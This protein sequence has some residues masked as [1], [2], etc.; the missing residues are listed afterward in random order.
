MAPPHWTSDE[1]VAAERKL[2]ELE[3]NP[4]AFKCCLMY[5]GDDPDKYQINDLLYGYARLI[6][7]RDGMHGEQLPRYADW[8]YEGQ[9]AGGSHM[10]TGY[11]RYIDLTVGVGWWSGQN[12]FKGQGITHAG[13]HFLYEGFWD[14]SLYYQEPTLSYA[15]TDLRHQ[16]D[17]AKL[18]EYREILEERKNTGAA[19]PGA[20][21]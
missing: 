9:L 5:N 10:W 2:K 17:E 16:F 11:G 3:M 21:D 15:V 18:A 8:I 14:M 4:D 19:P 1:Q 7:Y 6:N 20:D 12:V 13:D